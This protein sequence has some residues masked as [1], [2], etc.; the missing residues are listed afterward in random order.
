VMCR[1][2]LVVHDDGRA[3]CDVGC[4]DLD[5]LHRHFSSCGFVPDALGWV[6]ASDG[7]SCER[8]EALR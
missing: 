2:W 3:T 8:C 4:D 7:R 5:Q 6:P 1:G